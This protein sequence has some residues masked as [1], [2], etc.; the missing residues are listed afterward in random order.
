MKYSYRVSDTEEWN[1]LTKKQFL[2]IEESLD[3][4]D[5]RSKA[6]VDS[7]KRDFNNPVGPNHIVELRING[8]VVLHVC[9]SSTNDSVTA[10]LYS[11]DHLSPQSVELL[12]DYAQELNLVFAIP[13][14]PNH[15]V[16]DSQGNYYLKSKLKAH[17]TI[18]GNG[19]FDAYDFVEWLPD[20]LTI[21]GSLVGLEYLACKKFPD[22]L[23]VTEDLSLID[24]S[25]N[26]SPGSR[27]SV[28]K[29]LYLSNHMPNSLECKFLHLKGCQA[30]V[31]P[32]LKSYKVREDLTIEKSQPRIM[33]CL[34]GLTLPY[35]LFLRNNHW[36]EKKVKNISTEKWLYLTNND[37]GSIGPVRCHKLMVHNELY[38]TEV[39][40]GC[41][42]EADASFINCP[43]LDRLPDHLV[44]GGDLT[45]TKTGITK[46]PDRGIVF[47]NIKHNS[48]LVIPK[49]FCCFGSVET[50]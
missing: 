47:G 28:G 13:V 8:N 2:Q 9:L 33:Q 46:L 5:A 23:T 41:V 16:R 42:V 44:I 15:L 29:T 30:Q 20:H 18:I 17:T 40:E 34:W 10:L 12:R 37:I 22:D 6:I 26:V 35:S 39:Q 11:S 25:D 45:L 3:I 24:L 38:L 1:E 32:N 31:L 21:Q 50:V 4:V 27:L 49:G 14:D 7:V 19:K 48:P 43:A 36:V